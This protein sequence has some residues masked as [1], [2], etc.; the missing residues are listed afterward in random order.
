MVTRLEVKE[1]EK[2]EAVQRRFDASLHVEAWRVCG[3]DARPVRE[4]PDG[5]PWWWDGEEEASS[6]FLNAMGVNLDA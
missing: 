1:R 4:R 2:P 6:E 5:E 3:D